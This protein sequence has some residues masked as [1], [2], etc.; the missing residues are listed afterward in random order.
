MRG[1]PVSG[2]ASPVVHEGGVS[3]SSQ[4]CAL[5]IPRLLLSFLNI[6][7]SEGDMFGSDGRTHMCGCANRTETPNT[8][9][10]I[11]QEIKHL[12]KLLNFC[13]DEW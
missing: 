3:S 2:S 5:V 8:H 7:S 9:N 1:N 6:L 4:A 10:N 13:K 11:L 12:N